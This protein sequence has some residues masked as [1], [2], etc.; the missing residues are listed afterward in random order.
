[1]QQYGYDQ[2]GY[3]QSGYDQ[4]NYDY[5]QQQQYDNSGYYDN[6]NGYDQNTYQ[7]VTPA[8]V[9]EQPKQTEEK[10]KMSF[11]KSLGFGPK[12]EKKVDPKD[13]KIGITNDGR[14]FFIPNAKKKVK[15]TSNATTAIVTVVFAFIIAIVIFLTSNTEE[16]TVVSSLDVGKMV[17]A[18]TNTLN[19]KSADFTI[20][21]N[22]TRINGTFEI[23]N[24]TAD[25]LFYA[26]KGR[27]EDTLRTGNYYT[28]AGGY[29][30]FITENYDNDIGFPLVKDGGLN[31]DGLVQSLMYDDMASY[32][33]FSKKLSK[34]ANDVMTDS[35]YMAKF[36]QSYEIVESTKTLVTYRAKID[37]KALCVEI[38]KI[39]GTKLDA[40]KYKGFSTVTITI[41]NDIITAF[42]IKA[43]KGNTYS[44]LAVRLSNINTARVDVA[45]C[46]KVKSDAEEYIDKYGSIF[47]DKK[48]TS[49]FDC[50]T[51]DD[52][53]DDDPYDDDN[54]GDDDPSSGFIEDDPTSSEI[55]DIPVDDTSSFID[56]GTT[57]D[58]PVD[59]QPF[60]DT[61]SSYTDTDDPLYDPFDES[62]D[63][64]GTD[65][66]S[67]DD[68]GDVQ[69]NDGLL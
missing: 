11:S 42:I 36:V 10:K 15:R 13:D 35:I 25:T 21:Y 59:S 27:D 48:H 64:F 2:S 45:R 61:E 6:Y 4:G 9:P 58:M 38:N 60:D 1:N 49:I 8:Q 18:M 23:G 3:D 56:D 55:I 30:Y 33:A 68:T 66:G 57:S 47:A 24:S 32:E 14:Q 53:D 63:V 29:E 39:T 26:S 67:S 51:D 46:D 44:K 69:Y 50:F 62:S 37:L 17:T 52:D 34:F 65:D 12:E 41:D 40:G 7:Q 20:N 5:S 43:N 16:E 31:K 22:Y 54:T 28:N 19:L